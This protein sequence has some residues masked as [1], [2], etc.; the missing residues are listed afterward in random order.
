M[1]LV[2][3][4]IESNFKLNEIK[5][6]VTHKCLLNC[7]HCSSQSNITRNVEIDKDDC[8]R[9]IDEAVQMGVKEI[10]FSGG[11]P[12]LWPNL[13]NAV[14]LACR[15]GLTVLIYTSGNV[16]SFEENVKW[17]KEYGIAKCIFSVFAMESKLHNRITNTK[18][19]FQKTIMAIKAAIKADLN[20]EIHFVPLAINYS[21]LRPITEELKAIGI[22]R[23]SVLRFVPQGRGKSQSHLC[24]NKEQNLEL[25][26]EIEELRGNG[27]EVR[28]GSPYNFLFVNK[29][30]RCFAGIDRINIS[31]DLRIYPCDAFKQ[32]KAESI[33]GTFKYS[34]LTDSGLKTIWEKSPYLKA[35]RHYLKTPFGDPCKSCDSLNKCNSG[36][37]AQKVIENNSLEKNPDPICLLK[38]GA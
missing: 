14:K 15:K 4:H 8:F 28:T 13:S 1:I 10:A 19:S 35:V 5:L 37:L 27:Y 12:L 17:M 20:V 31:P 21:Q 18:N 38:Q 16:E 34:S 29:N 22:F 3:D 33:V 11:E 26:K 23:I 36:C 32:I 24:L 6:E 25:K 9:I 2:Q 7:I 30:P